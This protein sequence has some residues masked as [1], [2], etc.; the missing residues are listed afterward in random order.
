M[1]IRDR[2]DAAPTIVGNTIVYNELEG[3]F[4]CN[5]SIRGNTISYNNAG[6]AYCNGSIRDNLISYNSNA[7]GLYF[8]DGEIVGNTIVGKS[9]TGEA[10]IEYFM[11]DGVVKNK[12]DGD[13]G[14]GEWSLRGAKLCTDYSDD[15]DDKEDGEDKEN[16]SGQDED[17]DCYSMS[18]LGDV[19][20][21]TDDSG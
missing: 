21:L 13:R 12:I 9:P 6:V 19:L 14:E 3:I 10:Q 11:A 16:D 7:G 4:A 1:C 15:D 17:A 8:C 2:S 18:V 5:G 20:T